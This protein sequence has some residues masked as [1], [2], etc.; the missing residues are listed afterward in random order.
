M[1]QVWPSATAF[2]EACCFVSSPQ[3]LPKKVSFFMVDPLDSNSTTKHSPHSLVQPIDPNRII[4]MRITFFM[5]A[6]LQKEIKG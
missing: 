5:L 3:N 1:V 2:A 6:K 4:E